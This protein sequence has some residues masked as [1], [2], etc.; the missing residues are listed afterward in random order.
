VSYRSDP[1]G[2]ANGPI[3]CRPGKGIDRGVRL[4]RDR[5]LCV[6]RDLCGRSDP[7]PPIFPVASRR[8]F[9]RRLF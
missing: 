9:S 5:N 7:C 8:P 4:V 6:L 3:A 1:S 2:Q